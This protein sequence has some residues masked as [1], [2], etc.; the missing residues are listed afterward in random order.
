MQHDLLYLQNM[1]LNSDL[2]L[3]LRTVQVMVQEKANN[4]SKVCLFSDLNVIY[5][6]CIWWHHH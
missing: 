2:K 4:H 3:I 6:R 5:G 1:S